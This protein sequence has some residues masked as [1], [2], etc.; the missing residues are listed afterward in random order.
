LGI[1][2]TNPSQKLDVAGYVKGQTGICIGSDCRTSWPG[3]GKDQKC[4]DSQFVKEIKADGTIVCATGGGGTSCKAN[5][6]SC[7]NNTDCC[8]A[9]CYMG[10]CTDGGPGILPRS[11]CK[12]TLSAGNKRS[13][14]TR[15]AFNASQIPNEATADQ[16]CRDAAQGAGM[17]NYG[18]FQALVY[19]GQRDIN[20]VMT[21][22]A[23]YNGKKITGTDQCDWYRISNGGNDI[24]SIGTGTAS[25]TN[26]G[27]NNYLWSPI[28]YDE[29]GIEVNNGLVWTGFRPNTSLNGS[30]Q[31]LNT[32]YVSSPCN[33]WYASC[34]FNSGTWPCVLCQSYSPGSMG[35][36]YLSCDYAF[37]WYGS[38]NE[39]NGNWSSIVGVNTSSALNQCKA[40]SHELYCIER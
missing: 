39:K 35:G 36:A 40:S 31:L 15:A 30:Y 27:A 32:S 7:V 1:G 26:K 19:L 24:F 34:N 23:L 5:G 20:Q 16:R 2:T 12:N 33:G 17:S 38:T 6:L 18:N 3:T 37:H 13:F 9:L 22:Y 29:N 28:K 21:T 25:A 11:A 10:V 4:G 14:V 8:T